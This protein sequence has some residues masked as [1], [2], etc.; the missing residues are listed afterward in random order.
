MDKSTG[1]QDPDRPSR[2][3]GAWLTIATVVVLITALLV[4]FWC[5]RA[6]DVI[7]VAARGDAGGRAG[8]AGSGSGA[9]EPP[10]LP[11]SPTVR[12]ALPAVGLA[13][14]VPPPGMLDDP[15]LR[16]W[17]VYLRGR[18]L[19]PEGVPL[20]G[21]RLTATETGF[22]AVRSIDKR[23]NAH[24]GEQCSASTDASGGFQNPVAA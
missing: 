7:D 2:S 24:P 17:L 11:S 23:R 5:W 1:R 8:P 15:L 19:D 21:V 18:L 10:S 12:E 3:P 16:A 6:G 20:P 9:E 14:P 4:V 13:E 22:Y